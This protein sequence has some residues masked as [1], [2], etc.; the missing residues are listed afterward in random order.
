MNEGINPIKAPADIEEARMHIMSVM[1]NCGIMGANDS[2]YE[3]L[4]KLVDHLLKKEIAPERA[5]K[6]ADEIF[7]RKN[8]YH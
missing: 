8:P 2:E 5:K 3:D 1:Q 6:L 7:E 4:Q